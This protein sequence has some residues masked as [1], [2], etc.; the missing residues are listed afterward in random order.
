MKIKHQYLT[1]HSYSAIAIPAY[2]VKLER[3]ANSNI[4]PW[5]IEQKDGSILN[6]EYVD[7]FKFSLHDLPNTFTK[8]LFGIDATQMKMLVHRNY[9]D[10]ARMEERFQQVA[11]ICVKKL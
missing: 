2:Q 8:L 9:P 4:L 7:H 1:R 3:D 10:L 6:V 11:Y 5:A